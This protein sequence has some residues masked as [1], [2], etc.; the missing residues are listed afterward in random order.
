MKKQFIIDTLKPYFLDST[1]CAVEG[2]TC[3]Y[4]TKVGKTC[5]IGR[6]LDPT[7]PNYR[8]VSHT[9]GDVFIL[10]GRY[11]LNNVLKSEAKYILSIDEWRAVQVIHDNLA[12]SF[13]N[14]PD[15]VFS[16]DALEKITH[17]DLSELKSLL[18]NN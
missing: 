13:S 6:H 18:I 9:R 17:T 4:L 16:I 2:N 7:H 1:L 14:I 10:H 3:K 8:K 12:D 15:I 11:N 5:A